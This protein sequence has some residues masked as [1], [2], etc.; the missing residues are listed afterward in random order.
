MALM[1]YRFPPCSISGV[2]LAELLMGR[3]IK[4]TVPTLENNLPKWPKRSVVREK[5]RR[6]KCEVAFYY[7]LRHGARSLPVL[8]AGD[9]VLSKLDH[10]KQQSLPA[11]ISSETTTPRSFIIRTQQGAELR[12]NCRHLQPG[13][14]AQ[15][16][17]A[18]SRGLVVP[19]PFSPL[20][21][22]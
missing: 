5:N 20:K 7:N 18:V 8:R 22:W 14:K 11:V 3:K 10:E 15:P 16:P 17:P 12:R 2:S 13:P 6:E 1:A 21:D 9:T 4:T 19:F